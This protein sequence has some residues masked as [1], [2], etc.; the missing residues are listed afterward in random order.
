M[1][2]RSRKSDDEADG[3]EDGQAEPGENA[4]SP[5]DLMDA[6]LALDDLFHAG[7]IDEATYLERRSVLKD[8]LKNQLGS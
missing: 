5:D 4:Q 6:I 1:Y 3:L 7:R 2:V 8:R